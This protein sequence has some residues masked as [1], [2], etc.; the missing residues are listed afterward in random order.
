ME[1]S[2]AQI[3]KGFEGVCENWTIPIIGSL[4]KIIGCWWRINPIGISPSD[5][6]S[7][8][9]TPSLQ[10]P[11]EQRDRLTRGIYIPTSE[12]ETLGRLEK[13]F[14]LSSQA[15]PIIKKIRNGIRS[16][17]LPQKR[18]E[19]LI[20]GALVAGLISREE[21]ELVYEGEMLN[22][23]GIQVDS[24]TLGEYQR[25]NRVTIKTK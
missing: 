7:R 15:E 9:I 21:A 10:I 12:E 2:F 5:E 18:P 1:Y 22:N 14:L 20:M 24:F 17:K 3:Q 4:F 23:D 16:G 11:G 25:E 6:L 13:A 19:Q 8:K